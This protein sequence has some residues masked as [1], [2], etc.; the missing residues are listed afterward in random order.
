MLFSSEPLSIRTLLELNETFLRLHG[1][2]DPWYEEKTI[3]NNASIARF[4][5]RLAEI[6]KLEDNEKW[7]ELFRGLFAGYKII[8]INKINF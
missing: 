2:K 4:S 7:I 3:E 5:S 6:D 8:G 1:F